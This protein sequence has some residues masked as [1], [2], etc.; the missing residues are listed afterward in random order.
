MGQGDINIEHDLASS[1]LC[2]LYIA[3][4]FFAWSGKR[5]LSVHTTCP[6]TNLACRAS[7]L[8]GSQAREHDKGGYENPQGSAGIKPAGTLGP[9]RPCPPNHRRI[10]EV[11][12]I[13]GAGASA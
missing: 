4:H 8:T 2:Y 9:L 1:I 5:K 3:G 10:P 6:M 12:E 13:L 7:A 11:G